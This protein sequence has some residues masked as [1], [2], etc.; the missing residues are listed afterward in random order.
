MKLPPQ[1]L[2][3]PSLW[4]PSIRGIMYGIPVAS[5]LKLLWIFGVGRDVV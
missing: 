5:A 1:V 2:L 4:T 3:S